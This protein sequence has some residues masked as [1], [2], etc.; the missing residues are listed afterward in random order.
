MHV[1]L[2]LQASAAAAGMGEA[3]REVALPIEAQLQ[4]GPLAAQAALA[5]MAGDKRAMQAVALAAATKAAAAGLPSPLERQDLRR[6]KSGCAEKTCSLRSRA[7]ACPLLWSIQ[8]GRCRLMNLKYQL[9]SRPGCAE[10]GAGWTCMQAFEGHDIGHVGMC[11]AVSGAAWV[12]SHARELGGC[13]WA[14]VYCGSPEAGAWVHV[15]PILGVV[16][17]CGGGNFIR[18]DQPPALP[19]NLPGQQTWQ[20][21]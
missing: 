19:E 18:C 14:E 5:Q 20:E 1:V 12:R 17:G 3:V 21:P 15:D 4:R 2:A 6:S 8:C 9:S 11:R 16:D 10:G 13:A 7:T